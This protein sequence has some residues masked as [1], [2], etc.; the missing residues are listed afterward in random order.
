MTSEAIELRADSVVP[1]ILD[2]LESGFI[3]VDT[4]L[5]DWE[6]KVLGFGTIHPTAEA[7]QAAI[8][9]GVHPNYWD[10]YTVREISAGKL[11][12]SA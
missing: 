2:G 8:F 12:E 5:E 6:I 4:M 10:F 1:V 9:A 3:V 7:A 11:K